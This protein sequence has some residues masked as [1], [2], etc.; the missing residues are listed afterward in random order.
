MRNFDDPDYGWMPRKNLHFEE[1]LA[2][3][4][5]CMNLTAGCIGPKCMAWRWLWDEDKQATYTDDD[6]IE[7]GVG[8]CGLAAYPLIGRKAY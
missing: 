7:K 4:Q 2:G 8:W 6:G 1:T 3:G 5:C